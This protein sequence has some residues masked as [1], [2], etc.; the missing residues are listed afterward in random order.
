MADTV[1]SSLLNGGAQR[2][3]LADL[4]A[5]MLL[6]IFTYSNLVSLMQLSATS[7]ALREHVHDFFT[8]RIEAQ[9]NKYPEVKQ[10]LDRLGWKKKHNFPDCKCFQM[11]AGPS[12][13]WSQL[14]ERSVSTIGEYNP[15][16]DSTTVAGKTFFAAVSGEVTYVKMA[17]GVSG[18]HNSLRTLFTFK[19]VYRIRLASH[20]NVL[21]VLLSKW[22]PHWTVSLCIFNAS[23]LAKVTEIKLR[24]GLMVFGR[25]IALTRDTMIANHSFSWGAQ[26]KVQIWKINTEDPQEGGI[27]LLHTMNHRTVPLSQM[28]HCY[29]KQTVCINDMFT[30]IFDA[31]VKVFGR[32]GE[33]SPLVCQLDIGNP[34]SMALQGGQGDHLA[35]AF[36]SLNANGVP[37]LTV[38]VYSASQG[39]LIVQKENHLPFQRRSAPRPSLFMNWFG[40][41]LTIALQQENMISM[42]SWQPGLAS[43]NSPRQ[44]PVVR[45]SPRG[46]GGGSG[47]WTANCFHVDFQGVSAK[48]CHRFPP[49]R[50]GRPQSEKVF[51]MTWKSAS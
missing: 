7:N 15:L 8:S 12:L 37:E 4:P 29:K 35:L 45:R 42:L 36:T 1:T 22:R 3:S 30:V 34:E 16:E 27:S 19:H 40:D 5:E 38:K 6:N 43:F 20:D 23:T 31:K 21:A 18:G 2:T 32:Y 51:L 26:S 13:S 14:M 28:I 9:A 25:D 48:V 33:S 50:L 11:M 46:N 39:H 17:P 41:H 49:R 24:D 47:I 10:S 44:V